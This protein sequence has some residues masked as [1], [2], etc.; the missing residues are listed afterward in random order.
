[1]PSSLP[2]ILTSVALTIGLVV[3]PLPTVVTQAKA[4]E[5]KTREISVSRG[6]IKKVETPKTKVSVVGAT[7]QG[8]TGIERAEYRSKAVSYTHLTLPTTPYV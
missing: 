8:N 5:T 2:R 4:P 1:M 7:W 6:Q 3:A